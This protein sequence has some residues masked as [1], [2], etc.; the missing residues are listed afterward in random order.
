MKKPEPTILTQALRQSRSA[1]AGTAVFSMFI[2]L[3]M[4]AGPIYM[5]QVY[6]RILVNQSSATLG[7]SPKPGSRAWTT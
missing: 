6:D 7:C 4:L 2:N 5:L 3:L 1:I